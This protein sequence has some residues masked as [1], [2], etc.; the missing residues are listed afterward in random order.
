MNKGGRPKELDETKKRK[1]FLGFH[2]TELEYGKILAKIPQ[3]S[4]VSEGLRLLILDGV[5]ISKNTAIN[6]DKF[7]LH[8]QYKPMGDQADYYDLFNQIK[9]L[10]NQFEEIISLINK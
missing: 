8:S 5:K 2:V 7:I 9:K 10:N 3:H 1:K 4:S 6:M